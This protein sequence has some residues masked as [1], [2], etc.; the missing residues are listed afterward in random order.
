[1]CLG[2]AHIM[3]EQCVN[4]SEVVADRECVKVSQRA[5]VD[6]SELRWILRRRVS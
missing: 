2:S 6:R 1:M 3:C 4:R 5:G